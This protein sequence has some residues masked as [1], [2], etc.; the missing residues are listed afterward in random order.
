M[1]IDSFGM[2]RK[3]L[4]IAVLI[5]SGVSAQAQDEIAGV[6]HGEIKIPG[7]PLA[8]KVVLTRADA[9]WTGTI[10][11]P[12]QGAKNLP[13]VGIKV[14]PYEEDTRVTFAMHGVPGNPTFEGRLQSDG[15]ILG[16]FSQGGA[17]LEFQLSRDI[18]G[19]ARPQNPKAPFPYQVEEARFK[20]NSINFAGT[21]TIPAGAGPFPAVLLIS[22]SGPQNRDSEIFGHK[23]FL[24]IADH[25]TRAGIAVLRIDDP[26]VGGSTAHPQ[27]PTAA[28]F[29]DNA[30]AAIDFLKRDSRINPDQIGLIGHSEGGIVAPLATSREEGIAFVILLAAPGVPGDEMMR[31]QNE[32]ILDAAGIAGEQKEIRLALVDQLFAAL[33]SD[34]PE[35]EVRRKVEEVVRRQFETNGIPCTQQDETQVRMAVEQAISPGM[36]YLLAYDPRPALEKISVPV[37]TLN[38]ELDTQV[39][40]GQNLVAIAAALEKGGNSN[41]TIHRLPGLNHLFQHARTGLVGEYGVIEET[42]SPEVLDLIRDWILTVTR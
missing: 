40:A 12:A 15:I 42:I 8:I 27:P 32:R 5:H 25:L 18:T 4:T 33:T 41:V 35:A 14:E 1:S 30:I 10:D 20:H 37:L 22:G 13:L 38:G 16:T 7:Q 26:G 24:V 19:P 9:D 39:D 34:L 3:V 2:F 17:R 11:I 36:R 28:D 29:A 21:L 31:K 6:W 23:P